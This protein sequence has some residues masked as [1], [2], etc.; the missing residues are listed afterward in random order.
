MS[1]LHAIRELMKSLTNPCNE[2][3]ID[4]GNVNICQLGD[5][6]FRVD[7]WRKKYK[8]KKVWRSIEEEWHP[9][10]EVVE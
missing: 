10:A 9:T 1:N 4:Y 6:K 3:V 5:L 8:K 2:I 7:N